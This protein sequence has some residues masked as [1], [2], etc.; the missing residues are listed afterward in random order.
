MRVIYNGIKYYRNNDM[1]LKLNFNRAKK[2]LDECQVNEVPTD[3]KVVLELYNVF[4]IV[5]VKCILEKLTQGQALKAK[6]LMPVI[7]RFFNEIKDESFTHVCLSVSFQYQDDFW[8]LFDKFKVYE[9]ISA[10][11][12]EDTLIEHDISLAGILRN[13]NTV[14]HY[15]FVLSDLMRKSDQTAEILVNKFLE[16]ERNSSESRCFIPPSLK[17]CEFDTIFDHYLDSQYTDLNFLKLLAQSQSSAEFPISD[18]LRLKAKRKF[19]ES[20]QEHF[21]EGGGYET[22]IEV[23]FKDISNESSLI[24]HKR[25]FQFRFYYNK[26]WIESNLDYPTLLNN[27]IYLFEYTDYH[28]KCQ[29][30]ST[31]SKLSTFE[32]ILGVKGIKEYETGSIFYIQEGK[33]NLEMLAYKNFLSKKNIRIESIFEWFFTTYLYSEFKITGFIFN[34]PSEKST[35]IEKCRNLPSELDGIFKQYNLFVENRTIDRELLEISSKPVCFDKIRSLIGEKYAYANSKELS[36]EMDLLFSDQSRLNYLYKQE[37]IFENL[38]EIFK[39]QEVLTSDFPEYVQADLNWLILRGV[40]HLDDLGTIR[41]NKTRANIL[42]D[43][44]YNE[45]IR[46]TYYKNNVEINKLVESDELRCE[47]SLFSV[48]EQN[49]LNYMLNKS[50]YSNGLDLRNKYIH[51][52]YPLDID[53]QNRD[54]LRLLKILTIVIIKINEELCITFPERTE[55][56]RIKY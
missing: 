4:K 15:D 9:K 53:R 39:T 42:F 55:S 49:Y 46:P 35:I 22:T 33:S 31:K 37:K 19:D 14:R 32:K 1:T 43:L 30:T 3:V 17:P 2:K 7:A 8:E 36:C 29:F 18:E 51:S 28:F 5:S 10:S 23:Q 34:V 38:Y 12:L 48:P 26:N 56:A 47:S 20:V 24:E 6:N 21:E 13:I 27:F 45:V 11:K 50:E 44:F 54:Y 25:P 52:T 41:L 40:I 16:R